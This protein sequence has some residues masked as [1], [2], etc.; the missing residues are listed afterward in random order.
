YVGKLPEG[1]L[2]FEANI[3]DRDI[4]LV[5]PTTQLVARS[6]LHPAL[7]DILLQA[8]KEVHSKGGGFEKKGEFPSPQYI[9]FKL[10]AEA[11]RFYKSGPPF[12]QRYFP[13]WVANFLERMK[14]MLLP[15]LALL[16]PLFKTMPLIYR[17]R[18][19]SRIYRWYSEL[20]AVDPDTSKGDSAFHLDE[21][22]AELD[23]IEQS[24]SNISVP[25]AYAEG[26]F[27]LRMHIEMLRNRLIKMSSKD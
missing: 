8:A 10:S 15:M 21:Y 13:F 23:R 25:H 3:P 22:M 6:D 2:D 24:V 14:I 17:W 19:R 26:L 9:D 20:D 27:H 12:L 4:K 18:V 7:I 16:Y 5:A 1:V 11:E